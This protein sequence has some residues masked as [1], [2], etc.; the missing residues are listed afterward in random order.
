MR[1]TILKRRATCGL[2]VLLVACAFG[3]P[4]QAV[5]LA[6]SEPSSTELVDAPE[7]WDGLRITFVGEAVCGRM[8]RADGVWLHLNDDAYMTM[9]VEE[10]AALGGFNS[11]M[12]IWVPSGVVEDVT[13]FGDHK[14][15]GDICRVR[16]TFNAACEEHG[17]DMDIHAE[18]V[19]VTSPGRRAADPVAAW[20]PPLVGLLGAAAFSLWVLNRREERRARRG[21]RPRW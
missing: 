18:S 1:W 16:G 6:R 12:P 20:K 7:A 15:Q 8:E 13:L 14:H 11:G 21:A 2:A 17:G 10:G 5:A 4:G 19:A 9:N 3:V